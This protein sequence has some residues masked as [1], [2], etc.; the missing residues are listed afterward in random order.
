M[1][2]FYLL[3]AQPIYNVSTC[4]SAGFRMWE[5]AKT[6]NGGVNF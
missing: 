2:I 1:K 4:P 5:E 3:S 6:T